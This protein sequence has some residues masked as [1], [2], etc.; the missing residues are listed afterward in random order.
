MV[1]TTTA[2]R[3]PLLPTPLISLPHSLRHILPHLLSLPVYALPTF[4]DHITTP[5]SPFPFSSPPEDDDGDDGHLT[6]AV[7]RGEILLLLALLDSLREEENQEGDDDVDE[8]TNN[9][10]GKS[11]LGGASSSGGVPP[12]LMEM[13]NRWAGEVDRRR[14]K[15]ERGGSLKEAVAKVLVLERYLRYN[16][17]QMLKSCSSS[18]GA[19]GGVSREVVVR[20]LGVDERSGKGWEWVKN[21]GQALGAVLEMGGVAGSDQ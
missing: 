21:V 20:A 4:F 12:P 18:A 2:S 10:G 9:G 8:G 11:G 13:L 19:A 16:Q 1:S 6:R 5:S 3:R 7:L 14:E 17:T 15:Q